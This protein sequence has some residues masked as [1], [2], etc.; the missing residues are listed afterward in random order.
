MVATVERD[1]IIGEEEGTA[2]LEGYR[3]D[4]ML[5]RD[6]VMVSEI[7]LLME[8]ISMVG[9]YTERVVEVDPVLD[10]DIITV[11]DESLGVAVLLK[12]LEESLA[13][14]TELVLLGI[15]VDNVVIAAKG[16]VVAVGVKK[17]EDTLLIPVEVTVV[18]LGVM[19]KVEAVPLAVEDITGVS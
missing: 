1:A 7:P 3:V 13:L 19:D 16:I 15:M 12:G 4:E 18:A 6:C 2:M 11:V 5:E 9:V 8:E 17:E 14:D 10:E